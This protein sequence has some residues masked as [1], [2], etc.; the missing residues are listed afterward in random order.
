MRCAGLQPM[1]Q[2]HC[3]CMG[4]RSIMPKPDD[5]VTEALGGA[6]TGRSA[7]T[8]RGNF[9]RLLPGSVRPSRRAVERG[10]VGPRFPGSGFG[11]CASLP[12]NTFRLSF[13]R[14]RA[15]LS[16]RVLPR[17][18]ALL[19]SS[20]TRA[21]YCSRECMSIPRPFGPLGTSRE[22]QLGHLFI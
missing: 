1:V 6:R 21:K 8:P 7:A 15:S 3:D 2:G 18:L 13:V 22:N 10:E 5:F 17:L 11:G 16:S 4:G 12:I 20:R 9:T 14:F 19:Y